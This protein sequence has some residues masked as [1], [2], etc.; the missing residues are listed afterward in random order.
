MLSGDLDP[1]TPGIEQCVPDVLTQTDWNT[2]GFPGQGWS[3][4]YASLP[5]ALPVG[6]VIPGQFPTG[7]GPT[8]SPLQLRIVGNFDD[9]EVEQRTK[10]IP[11]FHDS[12]AY[13]TEY[14]AFVVKLIGQTGAND[15]LAPCTT[16]FPVAAQQAAATALFNAMPAVFQ[17]ASSSLANASPP[18]TFCSQLNRFKRFHRNY[19][20]PYQ[21]GLDNPVTFELDPKPDEE[22][23]RRLR[24][25]PRSRRAPSRSPADSAVAGPGGPSTPAYA[26]RTAVRSSSTASG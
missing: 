5:T 19:F 12:N 10:N 9:K 25:R 17:T 16:T 2:S 15:F 18:F 4:S 3:H 7:T 26:T 6:I 21:W 14:L 13:Q 11:N 22:Q 1:N 20:F 23:R 8:G 24:R